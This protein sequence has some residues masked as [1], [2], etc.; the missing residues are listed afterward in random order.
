MEAAQSYFDKATAEIIALG[1]S[2]IK[3]IE[4]EK[5]EAAEKA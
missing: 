4:K 5:V 3:R 2:T 1:E